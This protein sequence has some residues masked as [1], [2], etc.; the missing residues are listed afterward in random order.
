MPKTATDP[1]FATQRDPASAGRHAT[2]VT[3]SNT[4]DLSNVSSSLIITTGASASGIAV[5]FAD[6]ADSQIT[7][8]PLPSGI[9]V[10]L[11]MQVRRV[12]STGTN[13]GTGNSGVVATWG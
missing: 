8:I 1:L 6:D 10:Q 2:V 9:T 12:M 3:P 13:L 11:L 5:V 7:T 4:N